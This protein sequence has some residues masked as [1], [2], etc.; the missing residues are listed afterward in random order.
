MRDLVPYVKSGETL[1]YKQHLQDLF[2]KYRQEGLMKVNKKIERYR[3][4]RDLSKDIVSYVKS[5]HSFEYKMLVQELFWK[6]KKEGLDSKEAWN[7]AKEEALLKVK[8]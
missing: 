7:K 3:V 5:E 6:H 4:K 1:E 2:W 8:G